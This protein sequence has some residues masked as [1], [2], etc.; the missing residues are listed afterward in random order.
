[1][2]LLKWLF[3]CKKPTLNKPAVSNQFYCELDGNFAH[4]RCKKQ[5][6]HCSKEW[7]KMI[8]N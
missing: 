6:N 4:E 8:S 5:C 1:M 7:G 3:G 2:K